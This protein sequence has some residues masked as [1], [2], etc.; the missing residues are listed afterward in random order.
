MTDRLLTL[1]DRDMAETAGALR[2]GRL[3]PPF[4]VVALERIISK[5]L[6]P[7]TVEALDKLTAV[8]F[9]PE[10][11][12][13][14]LDILRADRASR[15]RIEDVLDLVTTG[16]DVPGVVNRDTSVVV[17]EL[18]AN[19]RQSVLLAG[20]AVYQGHKVFQALAD[21]MLD[22]PSLSVRLFLDIQRPHG[23]SASSS[24]LIR[25]FALRF[26]QSQWPMNRPL[27]RLY[28]DPRSLEAHPDQPASLHA[29]VVVVDSRHVFVSS[30]NFTP[31]AHLRNVEVGVT[32]DSPSFAQQV[33]DFFDTLLS[34]NQFLPVSLDAAKSLPGIGQDCP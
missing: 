27:P 18:F 16:P 23:N 17:R 22:I 29:K 1:S 7:R 14:T 5:D 31:A 4:S 19:A 20:Y 28:F 2:S 8:G 32:I 15:P 25:R 12:A 3:A 30:A 34:A 21:R 24:E 33:S 10:Q 9:G 11:I 6:A 13:M 26:R